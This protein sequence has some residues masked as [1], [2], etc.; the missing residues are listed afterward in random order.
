MQRTK[1]ILRRYRNDFSM[2]HNAEIVVAPQKVP[3]DYIVNNDR[4]V[5]TAGGRW[6]VLAA[7]HATSLVKD[8][9]DGSWFDHY[10][11]AQCF[12]SDDDGYTW[13]STNMTLSLNNNYSKSGL[14]EP[15][16]VEL[17]SGVLYGYFRTDL[18]CQYESLSIDGGE[19]WTAPAPSRFYSPNSPMLIKRNPHS[20][21]YY[22][23]WN[24][25][26]SYFGRKMHDGVWGRTPLVIAESEDG[27]NFSEPQIIEDDE[28]R[29]FCYPAMYFLDDKNILLGYCSG[30]KNENIC[31]NRLTVRKITLE[32]EE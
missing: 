8:E 1:Y 17:P 5:R 15:G 22:A 30:G 24:P 13:R 14:Q 26:P 31:L 23:V 18:K 29:G 10:G 9:G 11:V 2:P 6:I 25:T 7:Q 28:E 12:V 3:A 20:G 21:L 32:H 27:I 4:V 16:L 19:H